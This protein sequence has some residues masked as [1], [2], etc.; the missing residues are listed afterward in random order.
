MIPFIHHVQCLLA[1][2]ADGAS[3]IEELIARVTQRYR[4]ETQRYVAHFNGL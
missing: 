1:L 4:E 3:R 2:A